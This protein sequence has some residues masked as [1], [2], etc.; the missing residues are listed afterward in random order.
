VFAA[1][2]DPVCGVDSG[3]VASSARREGARCTAVT[4][5]EVRS[6]VDGC[7]AGAVVFMGA[8]DCDRLAREL[9]VEAG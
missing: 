2:E 4:P 9:M 7:G 5:A 6:F 3:L 1:R 8:G